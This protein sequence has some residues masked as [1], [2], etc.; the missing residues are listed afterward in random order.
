MLTHLK[1]GEKELID[2]FCWKTILILLAMEKRRAPLPISPRFLKACTAVGWPD[3]ADQ[4]AGVVS[5]YL[6]RNDEEIVLDRLLDGIERSAPLA[7][8]TG[9]RSR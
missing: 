5:R 8:A 1:P 7:T 4:I 3:N 6:L 9:A 2:G